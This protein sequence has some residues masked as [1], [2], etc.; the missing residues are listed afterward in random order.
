MIKEFVEQWDR[1]KDRLRQRIAERRPDEYKQLVE[2]VAEIMDEGK[3][4]DPTKVVEFWGSDYQGDALYVVRGKDNVYQGDYFYTVKVE[5][6]SCSGCDTLQSILV[7]FE[8]DK[9]LDGYMKLCLHI[10]Q[11][12]KEA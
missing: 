7:D 12:L 2:L 8:G 5:Y 4:L 10:V 6:G 3:T 1:K 9:Q 11:E